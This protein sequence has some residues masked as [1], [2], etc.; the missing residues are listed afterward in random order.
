MSF[1]D[2]KTFFHHKH[3][4]ECNQKYADIH[5]YSFHLDMVMEQYRLF[6][7]LL[8]EGH[9]QYTIPCGILA[10]DAISDARMTYNE[11]K[12]VCGDIVAD[13]VVL[14]TEFMRGK[15]RDE[16]F[17]EQFY[18]ELITNKL[19]VFVKLM[20]NIANIKYGLLTNSTMFDK[21]CKEYQE[22][23]VKYIKP[24]FPEYAPIFEY[25]EKLINIKL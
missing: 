19:A 3:D 5:P 23:T 10:H 15:T 12:D 16:R 22:K 8:E 6:S 24:N 4:I 18:N 20:D 14:C 13:I 1:I 17:P 21:Y 11:I 9:R 25:I 2:I 7:H